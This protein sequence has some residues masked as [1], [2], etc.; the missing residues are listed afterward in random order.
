MLN[1]SNVQFN[2]NELSGAFGDIGTDL[3]LLVALSFTTGLGIQNIFIV[4]GVLQILTGVYY[5]IPMPV[6]PLKAVAT[7]AITQKLAGPVVLAGGFAIGILMFILSVSGLLG[8]IAKFIPKTVIRG[9]QFGLGISLCLLACK[10]YIPSDGVPGLILSVFS[11]FLVITL[12]DNKKY[13]ASLLIVMIGVI[14]FF[15][16]KENQIHFSNNHNIKFY[17][18]TFLTPEFILKGFLL[19]TLPQIPLSIGNSILATKQISDD[20]FPHK[21]NLNVKKIG[22]T[23]SLLNLIAPILSGIPCCH[24]SGGMVG[25]Y[26]FG[27]RTGGSV[28][29]YGIFYIL[30]G[31]LSIFFTNSI[32]KIF[33]LPVLGV[34]LL[35]EGIAMITMIKD[36]MDLKKDFII[37]IIVGILAV[38]VQYGFLVGMLVG[39]VLCKLPIRFESMPKLKH[40]Q[41]TK[42]HKES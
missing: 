20:L 23:Y 18:L 22:I 28:V 41:N 37:S 29:I 36:T 24:G 12:I 17:D 6:Q 31:I 19:L 39:I 15:I 35:F 21:K 13:P 5:K 40:N 4:F 11:F 7:I 10:E 9:L 14:Y 27:G 3:P 16:F 8:Q 32:V 30:I 25:H 42:N 38:G 2:R 26:T 1:F 34:I 33:P